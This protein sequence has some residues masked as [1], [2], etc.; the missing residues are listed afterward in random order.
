MN[1][2]P[3][4]NTGPATQACS[5]AGLR[6]R[7]DG[8]ED[9]AGLA[10]WYLERERMRRGL[11]LQA[12]SQATGVHEHHLRAIEEGRLEN[13]PDREEALRMIATYAR[14]LGFEPEPL[15]QYFICHA[16]MSD[17]RHEQGTRAF[18]SARIVN[19]PLLERLR[20]MSRTPGGISAS[21]LAAMLLFGTLVWAVWPTETPR[22]E[23]RTLA[24]RTPA[25]QGEAA[26]APAAQPRQTSIARLSA[27]ALR[28]NGPEQTAGQETPADPI[29]ALIART[30]AETPA[31]GGS[32][33]AL[34]PRESGAEGAEA[35]TVRINTAEKA[36]LLPRNGNPPA[37][38]TEAA[39]PWNV[40]ADTRQQQASGSLLNENLIRPLSEVP[41]RGL[42]LRAID[43][44]WVRLVDDTGQILFAGLL[45]PGQVLKL[46]DDR[47]LR[48]TADDV[49]RMEWYVNGRRMG[50]LGQ[51]GTDFVG[52]PL[53]RFYQEG[54]LKAPAGRTAG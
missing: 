40:V 14:F 42:A 1:E 46:P 17:D 3:T 54:G 20:A 26:G 32:T 44:I 35:G 19:F 12:A 48:M 34:A 31:T 16:P 30:L 47:V 27:Q 36:G 15:L 53:G 4:I 45:R 8:D 10:G 39:P 41:A 13:L 52:E 51:R 11:S 25:G 50:R 43:R 49:H 5:H 28:E 22:K 38:D 6:P 24:A 9:P 33:D 23:E 18:S 29:G 2:H 21:V 7:P 37:S